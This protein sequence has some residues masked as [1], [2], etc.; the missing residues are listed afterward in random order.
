ML[1][2]LIDKENKFIEYALVT[3]QFAGIILVAITTHFG[4][5]PLAAYGAALLGIA[6]GG[7]AILE[8][9]FGN[10]HVLPR[11]V[12]NSHLVISGPYRYIRHPMYTSVLTIAAALI[13]GDFSMIK[14]GIGLLLLLCL[15]IKLEYEENLLTKRFPEYG[16]YRKITKRLVPFLW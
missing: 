15:I 3:G 4:S 14:L 12:E 13:V 8:M 11:L 16:A 6:F 2:K 1:N 10:F 9:K 7:Y 5:L